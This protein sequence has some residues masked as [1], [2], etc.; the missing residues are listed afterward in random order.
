MTFQRVNCAI[1]CA[2]VYMLS[3]PSLVCHFS[4]LLSRSAP[5]PSTSFLFFFLLPASIILC[6]LNAPQLPFPHA[7][8]CFWFVMSFAV[9]T[10]VCLC[11]RVCAA[12]AICHC[13]NLSLKLLPFQVPYFTPSRF[14]IIVLFSDYSSASP[15]S[16]PSLLP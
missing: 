7:R 3:P 8:R 14:L 5:L 9:A 15:L 16:F 12:L 10:Y 11:V 4:W 6:P 1:V 2:C 13:R